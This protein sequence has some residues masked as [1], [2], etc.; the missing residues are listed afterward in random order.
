MDKKKASK[1]KKLEKKMHQLMGVSADPCTYNPSEMFE[2]NTLVGVEIELERVARINIHDVIFHEYWNTVEDGSLRDGGMEFVLSRP[3]AGYDLETALILFD[4][5]VSKSGHGMRASSRTSVHVHIDIRDLTFAQL[6]R[7]VCIY[8]VFEDC[9][10]NMVGKNRSGNIFSTSLSNAEG[11]LRRLGM[12]GET[13]TDRQAQDIFAHFTKYSA[14]NLQAVRTYG[15][16][17]FRNHE[18][19]YDINRIIK[20]INIL[21]LMKEAAISLELPIEEMFASIS[22]RGT[23]AFFASVFKGY[24]EELRY[25][26][27]D[28]D[29]YNGLRLAQD[30]LYSQQL[31]KKID[32]P[33]NDDP[34]DNF[35]ATYYKKRKAKRFKERY[36]NFHSKY[37]GDGSG[38][39]YTTAT[40]AGGGLWD[41]G[42][43]GGIAADR[44]EAMIRRAQEA[45][46]IHIQAD[47]DRIELDMVNEEEIA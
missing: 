3:F 8:S 10:F 22:E 40:Y 13:P 19:T 35:Y 25:P 17:E 2:S 9:L 28:F 30:I 43:G 26:T 1:K 18:G 16:L 45:I 41:R 12:Y 6:T 27:L 34:M 32:L 37:F 5:N 14:C 33:E 38:E 7:F 47:R 39:S 36:K 11:E 46:Q 24:S 4:K 44:H 15:S 21:M 29:M 31:S 42:I 23:D 20:W